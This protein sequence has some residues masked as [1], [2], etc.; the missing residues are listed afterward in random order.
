MY[1]NVL[2]YRIFTF[3]I[4]EQKK[5]EKIN[6]FLKKLIHKRYNLQ[7]VFCNLFTYKLNIESRKSLKWKY[8]R[9]ILFRSLNKKKVRENRIKRKPI[10]HFVN[11]CRLRQMRKKKA[12]QITSDDKT[13]FRSRAP[14]C[15]PPVKIEGF[16]I[17]S[18]P[19]RNKSHNWV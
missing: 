19:A 10:C 8:I 13:H 7:Y 15:F 11:L 17:A 18:D 16:Q 14:P 12:K 2:K 9:E 3:I 4:K 5:K 6:R 1:C